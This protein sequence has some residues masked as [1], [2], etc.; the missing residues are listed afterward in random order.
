MAWLTT[1]HEYHTGNFT[2]H[3]PALLIER[4]HVNMDRLVNRSGPNS[5]GLK[6]IGHWEKCSS[7]LKEPAA[8]CSQ[9]DRL[10]QFILDS[11]LDS[12]SS[13]KLEDKKK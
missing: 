5:Q 10:H 12:Q 7:F 3:S 13:V 1:Q 2:V 6:H 9:C 11:Q 8:I 4:N